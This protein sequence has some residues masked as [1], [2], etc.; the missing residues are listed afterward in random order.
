VL[1]KMGRTVS[2]GSPPIVPSGVRELA[3]YLAAL[4]VVGI[5]YGSLACLAQRELKALIA[6]SSVGHMGFV[7]LGIATLTPVGVNGAL[8]ANVA[9]GLI[10]GLLFFL[11][12]AIK[13]RHHTGDL[14][15]LGG[16]CT[17]GTPGSAG[18]SRSPPSQAS[19]CRAGRLLGRDAHDA[20][21]VPAGEGLDRTLFLVLMALAGLGTVLTAAYLL[22]VVRRVA[23][24]LT[25]ERWRSAPLFGD[26]R[27]AGARGLGADRG[28]GRRD[29]LYA[30]RCLELTDPPC[31]GSGALRERPAAAGPQSGDWLTIA[32]PVVD[33]AYGAARARRRPV[34]AGGPACGDRV[35]RAREGSS[36]P[37]C[38]SC[39]WRAR[40]AARS[41]SRVARACCPRAPTSSTA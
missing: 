5:V 22:M 31:A 12:G 3:P 14:D 13:D 26:A 6:Y 2:C 10:T 29:R 15:A 40:S 35:A 9:H 37:E 7:L 21:G 28:R 39:R 30:R 23:Q 11:A 18:C 20:R 27:D 41:A 34:P 16:G 17:S 33:G 4:G 25:I 24:G 32:P 1:L 36:S 19:G 38:C 8:F